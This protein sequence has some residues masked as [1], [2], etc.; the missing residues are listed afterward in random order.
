VAEDVLETI[1]KYEELKPI[2]NKWAY[3]NGTEEP[4]LTLTGT[5]PIL[6][7][8]QRY[9]IPI[10]VWLKKRFLCERQRRYEP[11]RHVSVFVTAPEAV[12][13][14]AYYLNPDGSVYLSSRRLVNI[15]DDVVKKFSDKPPVR[16]ESLAME[17]R[18]EDPTPTQN[19]QTTSNE[20]ISSRT[21]SED[22]EQ[23][24][25]VDTAALELFLLSLE[26]NGYGQVKDDVVQL[27][28]S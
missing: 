15:L 5:V 19:N 27:L 16:L 23:L 11:P 17:T 4:M 26:N 28:K 6:H 9:N 2:L 13:S 3:N 20:A 7:N 1:E 10:L 8:G 22:T 24:H 14:D 12:L 25:G 18:T 21:I